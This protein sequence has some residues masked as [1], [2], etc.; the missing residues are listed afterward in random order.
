MSDVLVEP[1]SEGLSVRAIVP[2][3]I[4]ALVALNADVQR[5]HQLAEP[6]IYGTP[7]PEAVASWLAAVLQTHEGL[8]AER[9][10]RP[11]GYLLF[12]E[13]NRPVGPFT[14]AMRF[15]LVDQ[16][17][18]SERR[19]GVGRALM[20][21]VHAIGA[22]RGVREVQLD[23]RAVNESAIAFYEALGYRAIKVRMRRISGWGD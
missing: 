9:E 20:E 11:V 7:D 6:E 2:A 13:V 18:A 23:V 5:H 1:K 4:P 3:D 8:I 22:T 17:G 21:A 14:S 12:N 16:I 15:L 10:G 19:A